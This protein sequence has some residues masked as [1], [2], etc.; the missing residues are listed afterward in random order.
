MSDETRGR[1]KEKAG[2]TSQDRGE[3][4]LST[5]DSA[6]TVVPRE[7]PAA[8]R[9]RIDVLAGRITPPFAD[10]QI[11]Y[12]LKDLSE[13]WIEARRANPSG[14]EDAGGNV[15][16]VEEGMRLFISGTTAYENGEFSEAEQDLTRCVEG[17]PSHV[18]ALLTLGNLYFLLDEHDKADGSFSKAA[19]F[20]TGAAL[21]EILTNAG[22]NSVKAW[23]I[24]AAETYFQDAIKEN[25]ANGYAIND[26]GMLRDQ[27]EDLDGA[28]TLFLEAIQLMP[29]DEEVWYN[30]GTVL[31]KK[32]DKAGRLFCFLR[33]EERG[34]SELDDM[35]RDLVDQG[36]EPIDPRP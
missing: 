5:V 7:S 32:G 12:E 4:N 16:P 25:P 27:Q 10:L 28:E 23:D 17:L 14:Q 3:Q 34:F 24:P 11:W 36:I 31:G 33:A 6:E 26:L 15:D 22:M 35:I 21:S 1:R 2:K 29:D 18:L 13:R 20:C 9:S 8:I 30:L 19:G